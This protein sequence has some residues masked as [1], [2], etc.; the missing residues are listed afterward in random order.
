MREAASQRPPVP[1]AAP[2]LGRG[3]NEGEGE[4]VI[5]KRSPDF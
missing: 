1:A 4:L 3:A 5:N 2:L